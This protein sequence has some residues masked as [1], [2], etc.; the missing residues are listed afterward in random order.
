MG[1]GVL[2]S[3][4]S[5]SH[6]IKI[7]VV[8]DNN[9]THSQDLRF[10]LQTNTVNPVLISRDTEISNSSYYK[11]DSI[12]STNIIDAVM[13]KNTLPYNVELSGNIEVNNKTLAFLSRTSKVQHHDLKYA[14][15]Q[16]ILAHVI[17]TNTAT[18]TLKNTKEHLG[19]HFTA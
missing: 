16:A 9:R 11:M 14:P 12:Q 2:M 4:P 10:F 7:K 5:E 13:L 1:T 6:I 15:N 8:F 17:T 18:L 19:P 3:S